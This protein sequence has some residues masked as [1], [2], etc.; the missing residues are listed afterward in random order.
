MARIEL[1][2][3]SYAK[4]MGIVYVYKKSFS[5]MRAAAIRITS[6]YVK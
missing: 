2:D 3:F 4:E 6:F 1:K 5:S